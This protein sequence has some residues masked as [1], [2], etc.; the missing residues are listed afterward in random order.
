MKMSKEKWINDRILL[1][2]DINDEGVYCKSC[3][4]NEVTKDAYGTGDSPTMRECMI[5]DPDQC[6][7]VMEEWHDGCMEFDLT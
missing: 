3:E 2:E 7:G 6:P 1:M 4:H 5:D